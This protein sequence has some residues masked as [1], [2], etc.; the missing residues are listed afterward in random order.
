[1]RLAVVGLLCTREVR[2]SVRNRWSLVGALAFAVL[3]I[4]VAHLGM[5]GASQWGI[6]A[7]DRTAAALLNLVLLFV[8]LLTLPL[9]ATS[10]SGEIEDG[11]LS[12]LVAQPLTRAE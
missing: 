1:M 9:G 7:F 3:A 2:S 11:T 5:S 12:Y 6:S 8:P 10:F 4:A